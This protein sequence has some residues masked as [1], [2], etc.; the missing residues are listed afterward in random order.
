M[1]NKQNFGRKGE[2]VA[3]QYLVSKGLT[4]VEKN[5]TV[6]HLEADLICLDDDVLV[7]VEVKSRTNDIPPNPGEGLTRNKCKNLIRLAGIYM[8]QKGYEKVR[9]DLIWIVRSGN[10]YEVRHQPDA[11]FSHDYLS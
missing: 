10:S 6:R 4:V 3:A 2:E 9:F 7:I 11:F 8:E 5:W 1:N